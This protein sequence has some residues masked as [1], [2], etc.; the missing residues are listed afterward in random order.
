LAILPS[1]T[2][3]RNHCTCDSCA[4]PPRSQPLCWLATRRMVE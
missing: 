4:R 3:G 2:P 1:L